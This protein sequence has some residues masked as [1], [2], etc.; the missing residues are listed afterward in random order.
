MS[1]LKLLRVVTRRLPHPVIFALLR[2]LDFPVRVYIAACRRAP[3]PM[4]LYFTQV[5]GRFDDKVRRLTLYD[6]LNPVYARYYRREEAEALLRG[7]GFADVRS[8]HR[9]GYS[10]AVVGTKR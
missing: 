4:R 10:W 9:H 8:H 7:A 5:L 6:Q 3:L 2:L 1:L